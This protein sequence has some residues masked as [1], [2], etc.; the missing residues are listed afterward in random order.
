VLERAVILCSGTVIQDEHIGSLVTRVPAP[1]PASTSPPSRTSSASICCARWNRR[2]AMPRPARTG[3]RGCSGMSRS[4]A[5]SRMR[6]FGDYAAAVVTSQVG[7]ATAFR[8][9]GSHQ[10]CGRD[11][12]R[13]EEWLPASAGSCQYRNIGIVPK[14]RTHST[15]SS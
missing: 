10:S 8:L 12:T 1:Q 6:K 2:A 13:G 11:V 7:A 15:V 3:L 9:S 4:T 14:Y 5:W